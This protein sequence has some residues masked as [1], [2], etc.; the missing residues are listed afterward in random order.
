[1]PKVVE[2][3]AAKKV[4]EAAPAVATFK[5]KP[6]DQ[7]RKDLIFQIQI[8]MPTVE[9][10]KTQ[11]FGVLRKQSQ[12][13]RRSRPYIADLELLEGRPVSVERYRPGR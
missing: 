12:W 11:G 13:I 3:K 9:E 8:G 1:M 4:E 10:M 2:K 5:G 7:A 6:I